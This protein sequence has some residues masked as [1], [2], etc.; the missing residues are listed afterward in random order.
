M[1]H[2]LMPCW[3]GFGYYRDGLKA[4]TQWKPINFLGLSHV[5]LGVVS[6][7]FQKLFFLINK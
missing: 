4:Y 2:C 5:I 3:E 7:V 1:W 6:I